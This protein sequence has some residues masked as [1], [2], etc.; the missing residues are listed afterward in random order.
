MSIKKAILTGA[1]IE[2]GRRAA[3]KG[4]E[5]GREMIKKRRIRKKLAAWQEEIVRRVQQKKIEGSVDGL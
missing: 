1:G 5:R 3:S 4:I 2:I